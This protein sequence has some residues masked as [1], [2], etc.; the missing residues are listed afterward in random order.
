MSDSQLLDRQRGICNVSLLDRRHRTNIDCV[1]MQL[2]W[3]YQFANVCVLRTQPG[4]ATIEELGAIISFGKCCLPD[5][6]FFRYS[7]YGDSDCVTSLQFQ[8]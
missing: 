7:Y 6:L 8:A 1:L 5:Q 4:W 2:L 3:D